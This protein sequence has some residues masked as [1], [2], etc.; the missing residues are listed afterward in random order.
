MHTG[1]VASV[2]GK[3]STMFTSGARLVNNM[4]QIFLQTPIDSMI[5]H[6]YFVESQIHA[7]H[8]QDVGNWNQW[9]QDISPDL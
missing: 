6:L 9:Y 3:V 1:K 7:H 4:Y 8:T 2:K 5:F